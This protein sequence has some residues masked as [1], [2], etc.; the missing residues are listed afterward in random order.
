MD[1]AD[2][3]IG[4]RRCSGRAATAFRRRRSRHHRS[5]HRDFAAVLSQPPPHLSQQPPPHLSQQPP[6]H[7]SQQPPPHLSQQPPPHSLNRAPR[8]DPASTALRQLAHAAVAAKA[9]RRAGRLHLR[10]RRRPRRPSARGRSSRKLAELDGLLA[11]SARA[12]AAQL[13]P[14]TAMELHAIESAVG[15]LV[16]LALRRRHDLARHERCQKMAALTRGARRPR[17]ASPSSTCPLL[18]NTSV[19]QLRARVAAAATAP[20]SGLASV[21]L[22]TAHLQLTTA[23]ALQ[24]AALRALA[25][26]TRL[27][28]GSNSGGGGQ[29]TLSG[30]PLLPEPRVLHSDEEERAECS[31]HPSKASSAACAAHRNLICAN[32]R[33]SCARSRSSLARA[34]QARTIPT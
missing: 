6:P 27:A 25:L 15:S 31:W 23:R 21:R 22:H 13:Q 9:G 7:L 29:S 14:A 5:L 28:A 19:L 12:C 11:A 34:T 16:L 8:A 3:P 2:Q 24:R 1:A 30:G 4:V 33:S 17:S 32:A 18:N 20:L 10:H 26:P